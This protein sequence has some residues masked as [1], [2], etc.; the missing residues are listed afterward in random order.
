MVVGL[1][2]SQRLEIRHDGGW[3]DVFAGLRQA[4]TGLRLLQNSFLSHGWAFGMR[5]K[6]VKDFSIRQRCGRKSKSA[7]MRATGRRGFEARSESA[8][9]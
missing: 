1:H 6:K 7:S 8:N 5:E 4:V 9:S 3:R 2:K